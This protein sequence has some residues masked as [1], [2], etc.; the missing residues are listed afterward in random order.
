[1]TA[2]IEIR[3]FVIYIEPRKFDTAYIKCFTV[4][5]LL[6]LNEIG[7]GRIWFYQC[8]AVFEAVYRCV[9]EDPPVET[10]SNSS[11]PVTNCYEIH[12]AVDGHEV[13][14]EQIQV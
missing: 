2:K 1:M 14:P 8:L 9:S 10:T 5:C 4:R 3:Q 7:N 6:I 11:S 13:T 12:Y